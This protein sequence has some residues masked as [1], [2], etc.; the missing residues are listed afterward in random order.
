M[1]TPTW[2]NFLH[3]AGAV[4]HD[5]TVDNFGNPSLETQVAVSGEVI[6]DLSHRALIAVCGPDAENFLQGQLTN[7]VLAVTDAHSQL[8][9]QCSPKGRVLSLFRIFR[10]NDTLYLALPGSLLHDTLER[11]RK[12]V[13]MSKVTLEPEA[14][15]T[16]IGYAASKDDRRL[17]E[18]VNPL[19]EVIN[20]GFPSPL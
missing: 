5:G 13:L 1:M 4:I 9:A 14:G 15:L 8:S 18:L 20:A 6:A 12:Y 3:N 16:Q 17:R 19:P 10:R 7:D 2:Q 11:L